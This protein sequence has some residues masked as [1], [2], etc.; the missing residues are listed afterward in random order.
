VRLHAAPHPKRREHDPEE[1]RQGEQRLLQPRALK[2][3]KRE[4]HRGGEGERGGA[5]EA[6]QARPLVR[7]DEQDETDRE[8]ERTRRKQEQRR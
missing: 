3:E 7:G 1:G 8:L 5:L 6:A 2:G 4:R